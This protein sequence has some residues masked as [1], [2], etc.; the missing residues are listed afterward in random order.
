M[1]WFAKCKMPLNF[2]ELGNTL[3]FDK[4]YRVKLMPI[5]PG[6]SKVLV[7]EFDEYI[8]PIGVLSQEEAREVFHPPY[9][10]N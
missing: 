6:L 8:E 4:F 1:A 5:A 9:W 3:E 10:T 2:E 7:Y